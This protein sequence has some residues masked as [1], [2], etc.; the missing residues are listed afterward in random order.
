VDFPSLA[1]A[2]SF[3]YSPE[4]TAARKFRAAATKGTSTMIITEGLAQQ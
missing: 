3:Y 1:G 2:K 4:Y